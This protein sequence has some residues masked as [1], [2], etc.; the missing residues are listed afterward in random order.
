MQLA[1]GACKDG[2]NAWED[3]HGQSMTAVS[4]VRLSAT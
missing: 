2:Q 4:E 1:L 3:Q